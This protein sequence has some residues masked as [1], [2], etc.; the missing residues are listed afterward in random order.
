MASVVA[1]GCTRTTLE[2]DDGLTT[3]L[4]GKFLSDTYASVEIEVRQEPIGGVNARRRVWS[5]LAWALV[6]ALQA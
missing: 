6:A 2:R 5:A 1:A 3:W 4:R